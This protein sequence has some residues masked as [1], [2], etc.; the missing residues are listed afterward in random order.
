M[1]KFNRNENSGS[2]RDFGRSDFKRRDF[3]DRDRRREMHK[4][5]C[6]ECGRDCEVPFEPTSGKPVYCSDCFEKKD[7][8]RPATSRSFQDRGPR[9][10]DF[11]RRSEPAVQN[12]MQF[13]GIEN[14]LDRIIE[15]LSIKSVKED[16]KVETQPKEVKEIKVVTEKKPK[17]VK[18][19]SPAKKK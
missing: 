10:P 14:K 13:Q 17:T 19:K 8:A 3:G 11:Q 12:N 9:R 1:G 6:D 7:G 5:V 2:G 4:A 15:L 16:K 18:K